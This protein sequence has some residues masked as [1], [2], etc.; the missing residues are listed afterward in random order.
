[1]RYNPKF[2]L[3]TNSLFLMNLFVM[4]LLLYG[5][6]MTYGSTYLG[7]ISS[8][9]ITF[10]ASYF[11]FKQFF[12]TKKISLFD[13]N[14]GERKLRLLLD[15][16]IVFTLVFQIIHYVLIGNIPVV[17]A[18]LSSDYYA[19]ANIRQ[20]IKQV[21]QFYISYPSSFLLKAIIPFTLFILYKIDKRRFYIYL[22]IS[23]FYSIALMQKSFIV[24][25]LIPLVL[26]LLF[27]KKWFK[28]SF[29]SGLFIGGIVFLVIVTNPLL[30]PAP[31]D[32]GECLKA[33]PAKDM[34]DK[35]SGSAQTSGVIYNRVFIVTGQIVGDWFRCIPDSIPYAYG[36]GYR[37]GAKMT[38]KPYID[39]AREVYVQIRPKE[40]AMGFDG[41]ATTAHFMYDYANFGN[42]GLV[43]SGF[44][45]AIFLLFIQLFFKDDLGGMFALNGIYIIWLSSAPFTST[46]FSG[47]WGIMLV[48]YLVFRPLIIKSSSVAE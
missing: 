5:L 20:D 23:I 26:H 43:L 1:M 32:C 48:L 34:E 25:A 4:G 22:V 16:I 40:A 37:L 39:Y 17:K 10:I 13:W 3:Q 15:G 14:I 27:Q 29:Y 28:A 18:M 36:A 21:S 38:G 45:T 24:T 6:L 12:K 30:R 35:R 19:I 47:G 31:F 2:F 7:Q 33:G 46:L 8:Y 41:T 9:S 42:W 44:Y 11:V